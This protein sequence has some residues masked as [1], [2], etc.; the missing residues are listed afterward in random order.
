[1]LAVLSL[2]L[3]CYG[4]HYKRKQPEE[5]GGL[6]G[7]QVTVHHPGKQSGTW[8]LERKQSLETNTVH[9]FSPSGCSAALLIKL[10]PTC[11]AVAP[12]TASQTFSHH[13]SIKEIP[14]GDGYRLVDL[15]DFSIDLPSLKVSQA[16]SKLAITLA[17]QQNQ[18]SAG[19]VVLR[20]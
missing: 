19:Q 9:C 3:C 10:R 8:R 13:F 7:L 5:G 14:Q 6:F 16:A 1:M 12:P 15:D 20:H 11:P 4:K 17:H 18:V 2:R